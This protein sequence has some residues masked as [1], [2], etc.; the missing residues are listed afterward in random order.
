MVIV[1]QVI[2]DLLIQ[3]NLCSTRVFLHRAPQ[4]PA[5]QQK[6][7]F[8]IFFHVAPLPLGAHSG[9]L[10]LLQRDYQMSIYD[11]SQ[12]KALAI[13]DSLRAALDGY[14][15]DFEGVRFGAIF[16]RSQTHGYEN[17]TRLHEVVQEYRFLYQLIDPQPAPPPTRSNTRI[18]RSN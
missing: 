3:T 18:T 5:E 8:M 14:R 6:N 1:E 15:Q 16:Y 12:S 9:P 13:G 10:T 4:V 11:P 17:E 2:R 7:P